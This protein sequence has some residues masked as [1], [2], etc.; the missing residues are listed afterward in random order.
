MN[1]SL[2]SNHSPIPHFSKGGLRV[3]LKKWEL[4]RDYGFTLLELMISLAILGIILV[5]ILGALRLGFRSVDSGEKKM[6]S[7]ERIRASFRIIDSQVQSQ[8]PLTHTEEGETSYYFSGDSESLQFS[9]NYSIWGGQKGYV[10]VTY[11]VEPDEKGKRT[12]YASESVMGMEDRRETKLLDNF[13]AIYFEYFSKKP[14]EEE[15]EWAE[16]LPE[17]TIPDKLKIHLVRGEEDFSML[18]P[19]RARV[20]MTQ[21]TPTPLP[22]EEE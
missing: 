13:D 22:E 18:I 3:D 7:L 21:T 9:T 17:S 10:L 5:I 1:S 8:I 20:S 15:G 12:L 2:T 4:R 16:Q 6:D 19:I 14:A 11:R